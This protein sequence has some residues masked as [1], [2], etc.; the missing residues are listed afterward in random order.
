MSNLSWIGKSNDP[1]ETNETTTFDVM[2]F[3]NDYKDE[4]NNTNDLNVQATEFTP[5]NV[6]FNDNASKKNPNENKI[7]KLSLAT[8]KMIYY[9][10]C[11]KLA[12]ITNSPNNYNCI[13]KD[14]NK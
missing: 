1:K 9:D 4:M 5:A 12:D 13:K 11:D 2:K 7:V 10:S 8:D 6:T 3:F 14:Q